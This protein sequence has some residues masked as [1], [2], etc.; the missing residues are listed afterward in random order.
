MRQLVQKRKERLQAEREAEAEREAQELIIKKEQEDS[1]RRKVKK[2][3]ALSKK[4][5]RDEVE[6]DAEEEQARRRESLPST[7]AHG[8]ARQDGLDLH[9]GVYY[10]MMD[11]INGLAF[12]ARQRHYH[13]HSTLAFTLLHD[14]FAH[15]SAT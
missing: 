2:E 13:V 8:L 12:T 15:L 3:K 4:R 5:S 1:E 6:V 10:H 14:L 7:G 9:Q 11:F